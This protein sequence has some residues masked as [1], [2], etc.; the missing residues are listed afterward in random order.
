MRLAYNEAAPIQWLIAQLQVFQEQTNTPNKMSVAQLD[1]CAQIIYDNFHHLKATE[2]MLFLARLLGGMYPVDWH[3]YVTPTKIVF[4]L[5]EH[6]MPWRNDLLHKIE[7]NR[8]EQQRKKDYDNPDNM[9][10]DEWQEIKTI[11]SM[12]NSEYVQ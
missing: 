12:Y 2:I 11:I 1:T 7:K 10:Y 4:A 9:T 3:G 8:Q 6:F 5:R